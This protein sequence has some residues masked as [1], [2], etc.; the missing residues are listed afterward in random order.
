MQVSNS[1][2]KFRTTHV[3]PYNVEEIVFDSTT[4]IIDDASH[5][6]I[7]HFYYHMQINHNDS[8]DI[9]FQ[10]SRMHEFNNLMDRGVFSIV[11]RK[12]LKDTAYMGFDSSTKL[13]LLVLHRHMKNQ[14][15]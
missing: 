11:P 14:D 9:P 6:D 3:K 10:Q 1:K 15:L 8:L 7:V 4:P 12:K 5:D 2:A 13:K